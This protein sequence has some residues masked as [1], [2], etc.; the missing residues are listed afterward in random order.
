MVL[1]EA[2]TYRMDDR[3]DTQDDAA[4]VAQDNDF[5]AVCRF[6]E[7][8]QGASRQNDGAPC[9]DE[10]GGYMGVHDIQLVEGQALLV[11]S[12]K[13]FGWLHQLSSS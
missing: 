13:N 10:K 3:W 11:D 4:V 7:Y 8:I 5:V 1:W 9:G 12:M 6:V 2:V